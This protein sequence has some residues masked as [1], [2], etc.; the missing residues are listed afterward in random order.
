MNKNEEADESFRFQKLPIREYYD[1]TLTKVLE[2]GL[3]EVG[4]VR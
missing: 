3:R 4:R 1:G 2:E